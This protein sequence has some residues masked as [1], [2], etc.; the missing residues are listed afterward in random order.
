MDRALSAKEI[1]R[2]HDGEWVFLADPV[3]DAAG[4]LL[5]GKVLFHGPDSDRIYQKA[6]ALKDK[7]LRAAMLWIGV[8]P[9]EPVLVL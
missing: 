6:F 9:K 2:R 8:R 4:N 5:R 3:M 1:G 7:P